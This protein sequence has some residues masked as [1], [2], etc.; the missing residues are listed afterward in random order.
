VVALRLNSG[1][2]RGVPVLE[3][4]LDGVVVLTGGGACA[5]VAGVGSGKEKGGGVVATGV[6]YR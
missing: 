3:H 2:G 5:R 4:P 1:E 6:L